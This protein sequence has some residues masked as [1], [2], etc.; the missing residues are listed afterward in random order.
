MLEAEEDMKVVGDYASAEEAL[1]EMAK[2]HQDI[3]L[4][5][6]QMPGM[7]WIEATHN[8]KRNRL[9]TGAVI[10]LAESENYR[11]EALKAGAASYLLKDVTHVELVQTIRQVYRNTQTL[12]ERD[13]L[14][15][16]VVE[17]VVPP[18]ANAAQLLKFMCQLAEILHEGF[19]SIICAVGSWD[20]GTTIT[21]QTHS[22]TPSDL[23]ITLANMAEVEKVEEEPSARSAFSSFTKKFGLLPRSSTSPSK[24]MYVILKKT[25]PARQ[26]LVTMLE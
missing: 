11:A 22:T 9:N 20:R 6:T 8:L 16:E 12:K 26:K 14:V 17:L 24:R 10:I 21:I 2:L 1:T 19:A 4:M 15:E 18:Q 3:V 25:S 23:L 13:D 5:G 7:S